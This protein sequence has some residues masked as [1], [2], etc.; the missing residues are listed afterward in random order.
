MEREEIVGAIIVLV[1]ILVI[2]LIVYQMHGSFGEDIRKIAD[3]VFGWTK[4]EQKKE[5]E[6]AEESEAQRLMD[7]IA[8]IYSHSL[9]TTQ[10]GCT[11]DWKGYAVTEKYKIEITYVNSQEA[12][13]KV[14][15]LRAEDET[16]VATKTIE[17]TQGW[18]M[19]PCFMETK[20]EGT[21]GAKNI[22]ITQEKGKIKVDTYELYDDLPKM[23]KQ[24]QSHLCFIAKGRDEEARKKYFLDLQDCESG[25]TAGAEKAKE[26]FE[27][28]IA[29]L[30]KCRQF[31][32]NKDCKCNQIDLTGM[33]EGSEISAMN[34]EDPTTKEK[35]A[36][37]ELYYNKQKIGEKQLGKTT[38]WKATTKALQGNPIIEPWTGKE[39]LGR[40][41]GVLYAALTKDN[42]LALASKKAAEGQ[43]A[44]WWNKWMW[45]V[46]SMPYCS[47]PYY[48]PTKPK[49]AIFEEKCT[50]KTDPKNVLLNIQKGDSQYG[51]YE[52]IIKEATEDKGEREL[53]AAIMATESRGI[54]NLVSKSGCKGLMQFTTSTARAYGACDKSGCDKR[55]DRNVPTIAVPAGLKVVRDKTAYIDRCAGATKYREIFGIVAYNAG[56]GVI[57]KAIEATGKKDPTWEEAKK[58]ITPD[59]LKKIN[60]YKNTGYWRDQKTGK[61][62]EDRLKDKV[63]EIKCY[64]YYVQQYRIA[65]TDQLA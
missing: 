27:M 63:N 55:D 38:L 5:I 13:L 4:G 15:V 33:P 24:D 39:S 21:A 49:Y 29:S 28:L 44:S 12:L 3:E 30:E 37:F 56:E 53:L 48:Q 64:A 22:Q 61:W 58:E 60:D 50:R 54:N 7:R 11:Y 16:L 25:R 45:W 46:E 18:N 2:A 26:F 52:K 41:S 65:F 59:L 32:A 35:S 6:K 43:D 36:T 1:I 40:W 19:E 17:K 20:T 42:Q 14:K 8:E 23:Y 9:K 47:E 34:K 31:A 10:K 57:C 51:S 62:N